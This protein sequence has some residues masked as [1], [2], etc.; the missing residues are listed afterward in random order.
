[1]DVTVEEAA[2]R[3]NI[4]VATVKRRLINK[5]L[6]GRKLGRQWVVDDSKFPA[7][8]RASG[9][10]ALQGHS[11]DVASALKYVSRTDLNELWV[12][13]V[14]RWADHL[15]APEPV[16][17]EA[18][19]R[20]ST[21]QCDAATEVEVPKTPLL[22]RAAALLSL[23]D[24]VAYQAIV[25]AILPVIES[26]LSPHVYSSRAASNSSHFFKKAT[27]QWVLWHRKVAEQVKS[28]KSW[29]ARTDLT[30]YFESIDHAILL[31]DLRSAGAAPT[32]LAPL[33]SFL[34]GWSR[35]PGRGLPQGPNASRA[36]GNFYLGAVDHLMINTETNYSR[37]M[38]DV[39]VVASSK[40]DAIAG[41]RR[42]ELLCRKRG[43]IVSSNK[44]ELFSGAQ[45]IESAE[46]PDRQ[47]AQY[48]LD[49]RQDQQA[50][51]ALRLIFAD[52]LKSDG[53]L[54]VR[55]ATFALWRLAQLVDRQP[56]RAL[57]DRL[58]DLGPI[59][60]ISAAYLRK[61]ISSTDVEAAISKF[62]HD[63]EQYV[64]PV[65]EAWLFACMM[66]HP[67]PLPPTWVARARSIVRDR[68]GLNFHRAL[69]SNIMVL[70]G[71]TEDIVW[72]KQELRREFDPGMLRAFLVALAR[73]GKL[74]RA[75]AASAQSRTPSLVDTVMY[76]TNRS[77][78]PS[79]VWRGSNVRVK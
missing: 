61:F 67:G 68:N 48:L 37:Y 74:D 36:L 65:T 40:A 54:D 18:L 46:D 16:L 38:D 30:A 77:F 1:M 53:H 66:E 23:E 33:R 47:N 2:Q 72:L 44:T 49:S 64:S 42:F 15:A 69:A 4:S 8:V 9:R 10:G 55:A 51:R 6:T 32:L 25:G 17:R 73:V 28:G 21:G 29:V 19:A 58:E 39:A 41:I 45:A 56:L 79:L 22:T 12:P 60:R 7:S 50:R 20:A 63:P 57:L 52:A 13:D 75:T 43:L 34:A 70:S 11:L 78:L 3:L 14:L 26:Q 59:A 27:Q 5:Q 24:R 62:I 35:T 71:E 31:S 76:L